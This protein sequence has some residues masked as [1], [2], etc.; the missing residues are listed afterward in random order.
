MR[1]FTYKNLKD[2]PLNKI[3]KTYAHKSISLLQFRCRVYDGKMTMEEALTKPLSSSALRYTKANIYINRLYD[4][5]CATIK[6]P[7]SRKHFVIKMSK[8][9]APE[10]AIINL[11]PDRIKNGSESFGNIKTILTDLKKQE[12]K[13]QKEAAKKKAKPLNYKEQKYVSNMDILNNA[14]GKITNK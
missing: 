13:E 11:Y 2:A 10:I 6:S 9:Y 12:Q 4:K 3:H 1:F 8:G 5:L 7:V 14:F